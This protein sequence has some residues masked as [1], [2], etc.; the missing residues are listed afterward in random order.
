MSPRLLNRDRSCVGYNSADVHF[1][2]TAK[3]QKQILADI[4]SGSS[5]FGRK[6]HSAR[7]P[8]A[9]RNQ[10]GLS[11][12]SSQDTVAA[13]TERAVEDTGSRG[14]KSTNTTRP[15]LPKRTS[16]MRRAYNYFFGSAGA[17]PTSPT[18]AVTTTEAHA[19]APSKSRPT[20][21]DNGIDTPPETPRDA[22]SG[23]D[24]GKQPLFHPASPA[25]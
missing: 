3:E 13:A 12:K 4:E 15:G 22:L 20:T 7:P 2:A 11:Q 23:A 5:K 17:P 6:L 14:R 19:P 24:S 21:G 16:S 10:S 9:H 25:Q 1:S 18:T 8:Q